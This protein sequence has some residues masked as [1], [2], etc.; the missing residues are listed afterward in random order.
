MTVCLARIHVQFLQIITI[1]SCPFCPIPVSSGHLAP[2]DTYT[3]LSP[4]YQISQFF[5]LSVK[6]PGC[7]ARNRIYCYNREEMVTPLFNGLNSRLHFN[8]MFTSF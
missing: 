2:A 1:G 4:F 6:Q 8:V 3:T 7:F 5:L